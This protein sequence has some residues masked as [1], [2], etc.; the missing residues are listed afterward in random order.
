M[1]IPEKKS[2]GSWIHKYKYYFPKAGVHSRSKLS[3]PSQTRQYGIPYVRVVAITV[4]IIKPSPQL[5]T[6]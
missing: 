3:S 1:W 2:T 6:I 5:G 4:L